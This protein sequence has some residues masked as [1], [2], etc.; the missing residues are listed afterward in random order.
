MVVPEMKY[1]HGDIVKFNFK[2]NSLD[3]VGDEVGLIGVIT[4]ISYEEK[5]YNEIKISYSVQLRDDNRGIYGKIEV[6]E[7]HITGVLG[8]KQFALEY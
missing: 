6:P 3:V 8:P 7:K 5:F 1:K 4:A 2:P